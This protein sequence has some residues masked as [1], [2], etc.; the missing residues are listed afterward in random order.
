MQTTTIQKLNQFNKQFYLDVAK[1]FTQ[2]RNTFWQG[3]ECLVPHISATN[4]NS[5]SVLDVGCGNGRF[6]QFLVQQKPDLTIKY[7]GLDNS[8]PLLRYAGEKL[9]SV[10]LKPQL[11]ELDLIEQLLSKKHLVENQL[12]D[13]V[14]AFGV[15]H[16]I[17]S[18]DL[19]TKLFEQLSTLV[20]P[21]G[22][23]SIGF[24]QFLNSVK[25]RERTVDPKTLD[26]NAT[27]FEEND[28]ILDWRAGEKPAYRYCHYTNN[29]EEI[30]LVK[31]SKLKVIDE[32]FADGATHNL[33]HYLVLKRL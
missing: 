3:W 4:I 33:N 9:Q 28:Y 22:I 11:I 30:A 31:Q 10:K 2:T 5:V 18:I 14:V 16:H 15:F 21:N 29:G 24:W 8:A 32:Y 26:L 1:D 25:L 7:T 17:P 19:R 12:F 20:A 13:A 6:G 27:E 23:L